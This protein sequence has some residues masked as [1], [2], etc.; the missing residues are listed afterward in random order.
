MRIY[1]YDGD[2][3]SRDDQHFELVLEYLTVIMLKYR[4]LSGGDSQEGLLLRLESAY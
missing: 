1:K 2:D 3:G 4:T